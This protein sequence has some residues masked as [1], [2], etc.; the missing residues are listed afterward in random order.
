MRLSNVQQLSGRGIYVTTRQ[1]LN[2][3][4][5]L[6]DRVQELLGRDIY[7]TAPEP[8]GDSAPYGSAVVG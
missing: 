8:Y 5:V 1:L 4:V 6:H 7:A 3:M 2:P